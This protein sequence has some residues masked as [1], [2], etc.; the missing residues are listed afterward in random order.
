MNLL[1]LFDGLRPNTIASIAGVGYRDGVPADEAAAGW[2]LGVVRR[3]DG[4][5]IVADYHGNRIWRIDRDGILHTFAGDGVP[6]DSGD[7]GPAIAARL[8]NPHDLSLDGEGN[9]YLSDLGN[10]T[11]RRIDHQTGVIT[12]LAGSGKVGRGGDGGPADSACTVTTSC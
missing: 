3:P 9:L 2:P 11:Y 12:R 1:D 4:D 8:N 5:L 7:G 10:Q 6:G